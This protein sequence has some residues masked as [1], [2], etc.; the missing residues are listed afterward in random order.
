MHSREFLRWFVAGLVG[1][2]VFVAATNMYIDVYGLFR[3]ASGRDIMIYG[4]ERSAKFLHSFR[5]IPENFDGI[6]MG[7]SVCDNLE[8]DS[9]SGHRV[10]NASI[11][12][13]NVDDL[14]PIAGNVFR[15]RHMDLA[16]L[17]I[18]RY[19]TL[20]H[21]SKTDLMSPRQYWS[22]LGSPQL[23]GVYLARSVT[24]STFDRSGTRHFASEPPMEARRER[25]AETVAEIRR[26]TAQVGNYSIDP[27]A[28][29]GLG[30]LIELAR[31][32]SRHLIIFY[33]P[34]PQSILDVCMS[35]YLAYK[36][37]IQKLTRPT[38]VVIDFNAAEFREAREQVANF[39]D[40][41]H[42][43]QAGARVVT[44]ELNQTVAQFDSEMKSA[45][46]P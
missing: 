43:S 38:D 14:E 15:R 25:I 16:V 23:I 33:P 4:E 36:E 34:T 11:N 35:D 42:L 21:G 19:L 13:G 45:R 6:L 24:F 8:T 26:G 18:H 10:Y 17:C 31:A 28:Y 40:A 12:G 29:A 41:V 9:I 37:A 5:Y 3:P 1:L 27:V 20:D 2:T 44:G 22:A 32:N 30:R 39:V 7:S 46:V